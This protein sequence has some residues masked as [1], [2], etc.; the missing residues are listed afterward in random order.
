MIFSVPLHRSTSPSRHRR[1]I[2]P[3]PL[4]FHDQ[5]TSTTT[6]STSDHTAIYFSRLI[7]FF[8]CYIHSSSA[9]HHIQIHHL[10]IQRRRMRERQH[11]GFNPSSTPLVSSTRR[12]GRVC[13][14]F[15]CCQRFA[16]PSSVV[17]SRRCRT[18]RQKVED[19]TP[20][21]DVHRLP[22]LPLTTILACSTLQQSDYAGESIQYVGG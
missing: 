20:P 21:K 13:G 2:P 8:A 18:R 9:G 7:L 1:N 17:V 10:V 16:S 12:S 14:L 3:P 5:H 6:G 15:Q 11:V 22:H 19:V 4:L